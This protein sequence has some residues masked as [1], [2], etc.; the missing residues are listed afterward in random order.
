MNKIETINPI[1][2][3]LE[4]IKVVISCLTPLIVAY[5]VYYFNKVIKKYE[6]IQWTNQKIIEKRILIYDLVVPKLNDLFCFFCFIGNWKELTPKNIIK[7][8]RELDKQIYI[9]EPL[10]SQQLIDKYNVLLV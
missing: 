8:K 10:F 4:I 5:L 2:N 9:Y 1:W 3:S 6:K 7:L